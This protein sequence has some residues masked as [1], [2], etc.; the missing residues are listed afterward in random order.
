MSWRPLL[1]P[2]LAALVLGQA[3][4]A[5]ALRDPLP[6]RTVPGCDY[7]RAREEYLQAYAYQRERQ[8]IARKFLTAA[9]AELRS[10]AGEHAALSERIAR[11]RAD[12]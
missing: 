1:A 5:P 9:E 6:P 4:D 3:A 11:L 2:V 8:P 7:T 10:C 12:L